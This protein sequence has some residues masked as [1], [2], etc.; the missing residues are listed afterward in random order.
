[1]WRSGWGSCEENFE[2]SCEERV[3]YEVI[4]E[5]NCEGFDERSCKCQA[6]FVVKVEVDCEG[7]S[8][9]VVEVG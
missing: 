3:S 2:V 7:H 1:M 8:V 5:G 6:H 4:G 9:G